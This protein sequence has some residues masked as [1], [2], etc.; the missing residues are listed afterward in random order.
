M[1]EPLTA[2]QEQLVLDHMGHARAYVRR[3]FKARGEKLDDYDQQAYIGLVYAARRFKPEMGR[4]FWAYAQAWVFKYVAE[5]MGLDRTIRPPWKNVRTGDTPELLA[6]VPLTTTDPER[7]DILNAWGEEEEG[8][9]GVELA[10]LHDWFLRT[11][12]TWSTTTVQSW[13]AWHER[14]EW[15]AATS[16]RDSIVELDET[17]RVGWFE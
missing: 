5:Y 4:P 11:L 15:P 16:V 9:E 17:I 14:D 8:F 2:F 1:T 12:S 10:E 3:R 13:W 7:Q 6:D